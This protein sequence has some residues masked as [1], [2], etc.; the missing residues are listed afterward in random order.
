MGVFDGMLGANESLFRNAVALD[1]DFALAEQL[2]RATPDGIEELE[3][4]S[5]YP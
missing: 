2:W 5:A 4:S 1:F 3:E